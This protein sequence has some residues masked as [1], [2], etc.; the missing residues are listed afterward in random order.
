M[1]I[2]RQEHG[3]W[4]AGIGLVYHGHGLFGRRLFSFIQLEIMNTDEM[5]KLN[6][7]AK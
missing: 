5:N 2:I 3:C 6:L 4:L 7:N 1:F